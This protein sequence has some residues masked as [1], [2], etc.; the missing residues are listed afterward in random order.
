MDFSL[1][2]KTDPYILFKTDTFKYASPL[3]I[4]SL[5]LKGEDGIKLCNI[6]K[7]IQVHVNEHLI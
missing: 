4:L 3:L 7:A 1:P 2:Y 5:N 6:Y